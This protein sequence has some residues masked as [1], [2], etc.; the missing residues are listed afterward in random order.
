M[1]GSFCC[2][3]EGWDSIHVLLFLPSILAPAWPRARWEGTPWSP[4]LSVPSHPETEGPL[5]GQMSLSPSKKR[6]EGQVIIRFCNFYWYYLGT[7]KWIPW[8]SPHG[9]GTKRWL[10]RTREGPG[11]STRPSWCPHTACPSD[12]HTCK[13]EKIIYTYLCIAWAVLQPVWLL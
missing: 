6:K 10:P 11:L 7:I 4:S 1:R 13:K 12:S 5:L 3:V 2:L 8:V 9:L